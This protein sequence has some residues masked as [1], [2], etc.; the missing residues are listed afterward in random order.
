M[1]DSS[2]PEIVCDTGPLSALADAGHLEILPMIAQPKVVVIPDVVE[3]EL[4]NGASDRPQID[5]LLNAPWLARVTLQEDRE[6]EELG[7][8]SSFLVSGTKNLGEAAVLAYAKA[9]DVT[10]VIDDR[11][12]SNVGRREGVKIRGTLGLLLDA[13]GRELLGID[14]VSELAD[15]LIMVKYRLPFKAGGFKDWAENE[16]FGFTAI[17]APAE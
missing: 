16:G 10:A 4:R 1:A 8:F 13:V 6:I 9:H 15:E 11:T 17:S 7:R 3:R 2:R 12:A 5:A 14:E